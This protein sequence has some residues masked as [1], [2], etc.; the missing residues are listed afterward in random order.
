MFIMPVSQVTHYT[1]Q[2]IWTKFASAE[3]YT[4]LSYQY[5]MLFTFQTISFRE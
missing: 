5:L 3:L 2:F 4:K 1:V